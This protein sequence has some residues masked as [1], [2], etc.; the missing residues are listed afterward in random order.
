MI[1]DGINAVRWAWILIKFGTEKAVN[2]Y[3]DWWITLVRRN[4]AKLPQIKTLWESFAWDIAMRMRQTETFST[5]TDELMADL[6]TVN[7]A[8]MQFFQEE[9]EDNRQPRSLPGARQGHQSQRQ[10][11]WLQREGQP[12]QGVESAIQH[13]AVANTVQMA[14]HPTH[15]LQTPRSSHS[16]ALCHSPTSTGNSRRPTPG[17]N[18]VSRHSSSSPRAKARTRKATRA[19][20]AAKHNIRDSTAQDKSLEPTQRRIATVHQALLPR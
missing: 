6:S 7:D 12:I 8:L 4:S 13:P 9:A 3:C 18:Q 16:L 5:I 17:N 10:G 15:S 14:Q 11:P 19:A 1:Q 2:K 20:A